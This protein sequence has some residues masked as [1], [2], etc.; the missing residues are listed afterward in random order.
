MY[1]VVGI[2]HG[3]G[4]YEGNAYDNFKLHCLRDAK[5]G[6]EENG[7]ITEVL[8]LKS[9]L[10]LSS[11]ICLGSIVTPYYDKYGRIVQ[12]IVK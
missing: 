4:T 2:V 10:F 9:D 8:K 1:T 11:D 5:P 7:Q 6:T 3:S 12:L